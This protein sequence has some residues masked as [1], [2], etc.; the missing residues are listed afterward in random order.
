ML[1]GHAPP[2]QMI[3]SYSASNSGYPSININPRNRPS[4]YRFWKAENLENA[5][6]AVERGESIRKS[7]EIHGVPKFTLS[8]YVSG[9]NRTLE[10]RSGAPYLTMAEEEEL[11]SFLITSD[12]SLKNSWATYGPGNSNRL[13]IGIID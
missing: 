5:I 3:I 4:T 2:R 9:K 13:E 7:A 1:H 10:G 12:S 8:D 6:K 11:F